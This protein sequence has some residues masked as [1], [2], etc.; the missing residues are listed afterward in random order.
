MKIPKEIIQTSMNE[1]MSED[2]K[3]VFKKIGYGG[4]PVWTDMGCTFFCYMDNKTCRE[5]KGK[6]HNV[7]MEY[8]EIAGCPLIRFD[9]VVYDDIINPLH[10]DS[11]LNISN[12]DHEC[13]L[14]ALKEQERIIFHWYDKDFKYR[15]STAVKWKEE[16]RMITGEIIEK[17]RECV[18]KK[19]IKD[20]DKA[21]DKFMRKN[22]L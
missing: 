6:I 21:K 2:L 10:F 18:E 22:P 14:D 1:L 13:M 3:K 15:G 4:I 16:N 5:V 19:G 12:E 20:F 11:F 17:G 8:H 7:K 9:I